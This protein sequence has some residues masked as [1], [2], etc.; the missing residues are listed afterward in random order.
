MANSSESVTN[1]GT[2]AFNTCLTLATVT[3]KFSESNKVKTIGNSVFAFGYHFPN[4]ERFP[5]LHQRK[6]PLNCSLGG[7]FLWQL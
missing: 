1:I 3:M 5:D 7:F 4:T 2:Y 6:I